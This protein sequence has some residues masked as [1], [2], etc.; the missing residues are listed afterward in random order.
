MTF[1][2]G[3]ADKIVSKI[4]G[5]EEYNRSYKRSAKGGYGNDGTEFD[6]F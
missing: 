6:K 3:K 1:H 2:C 4:Y 5:M